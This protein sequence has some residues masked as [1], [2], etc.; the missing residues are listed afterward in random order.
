MESE[1]FKRENPE[2]EFI[3]DDQFINEHEYVHYVKYDS[4]K[5]L[6][7]LVLIHGY[8]GGCYTYFQMT[9][10]LVPHFKL[11]IVD[12]PGMGL[13]SR[14]KFIEKF[15]SFD[16]YMNYFVKTLH[17]FF[18][19]MNLSKFHL[20]GHSIGSLISSFYFDA[21][22]NE[23]I[24]LILLS[25][26]GFNKHDEQAEKD[27]SK[28][29]N[30]QGFFKKTIFNY[31]MRKVYGEKKSPLSLLFMPSFFIGKYLNAERFKFTK[32][33][34]TLIK[35]ILVY[36]ISQKQY[37]ECCIGYFLYDVKSKKPIREVLAK[38]PERLRDVL[39][40]FGDQDWMD[41][42]ET[43]DF[44]RKSSWNEV[45]VEI[46]NGADHQIIFQNP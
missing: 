30:Q 5:D 31:T 6:P 41:S 13:N 35:K 23:V 24:K 37:S 18:G 1:L 16:E 40:L 36:Y 25:P 29:L 10:Y 32:E 2:A 9:K 46:I 21:Y 3:Q 26:A 28:W 17:I 45:K 22:P 15:K 39:I 33:E 19:L 27:L 20:A 44:V 4:D 11:L 8:G 42:E 14:N 34:K 38:R 12:I 7:W 43:L